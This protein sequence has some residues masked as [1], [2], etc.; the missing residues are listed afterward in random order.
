[1]W[2]VMGRSFWAVRQKAQVLNKD[3]NIDVISANKL[4]TPHL[5]EI[6]TDKKSKLSHPSDEGDMSVLA[7]EAIYQPCRAK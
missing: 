2:L 7:A 6:R 3:L 1:M 4:R 5:V